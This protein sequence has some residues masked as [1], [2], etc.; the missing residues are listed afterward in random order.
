MSSYAAPLLFV[1]AL[2]WNS[3]ER[4][5]VTLVAAAAG[6]AVAFLPSQFVG[7]FE[8]H[9]QGSIILQ[10]IAVALMVREV[11]PPTDIMSCIFEFRFPSMVVRGFCRPDTVTGHHVGANAAAALHHRVDVTGPAAPAAA[12][13]RLLQR[14]ARVSAAGRGDRPADREAV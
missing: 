4:M 8:S 10:F 13:K 9:D 1:A 11:F 14:P 2:A 3:P 6:C 7:T 12:G 5:Q